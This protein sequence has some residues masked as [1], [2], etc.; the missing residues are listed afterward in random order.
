MSQT[1]GEL[2]LSV[3]L[4]ILNAQGN[5]K[6]FGTSLDEVAGKSKQ[7]NVTLSNTK[8]TVT[9]LAGAFTN[10]GLRVEG[11]FSIVRVMQSTFGSFVQEYKYF[12][13]AQ[14]GLSSIASFKM[15]DPETANQQIQSLKAV[16]AGLLDIGSASTAM[17]NLLASNFT[18]EQSVELINRLSESAAF[19]RQS[20]LSFGEAVRSATEGIK[21]GNSILVDNAGVTKNL[22]VMLEEA[23][24]KA[25]DLMRA[26]Q[27]A[28]VRMA[29]FSSILRE[30]AGNVGDVD[31]LSSSA[32]GQFAKFEFAITKLKVSFGELITK[33]IGPGIDVLSSIIN[34]LAKADPFLAKLSIT[35][36]A[37]ASA[38]VV[39]NKS[40]GLIPYVLITAAGILA[41]LP[42]GLRAVAAAIMLVVGGVW[43][44][45]AA[46]AIANV[47]SGGLITAIGLIVTALAALGS[48][49]FGASDQA[50]NFTEQVN[51]MTQKLGETNS[52]L[53]KLS[54]LEDSFSITIPTDDDL[55]QRQDLLKELSETYPQLIIGVNQ[56][57]GELQSNSVRV[58]EVIQAE[59][60]LQEI[61]NTALVYKIASGIKD[62]TDEYSDQISTFEKVKRETEDYRKQA[63]A[64]V[65]ANAKLTKQIDNHKGSTFESRRELIN[66][67]AELRSNQ[68]E[69]EGLYEKTRESSSEM[70]EGANAAAQLKQQ[71]ID[72]ISA[73]L[74]TG[75]L[76]DVFN[77][78]TMSLG[79][80]SQAAYS[81]QG[82]FAS[83]STNAIANLLGI[84][85]SAQN[86]AQVLWA[87]SKG[88]A[89]LSKG[90]FASAEAMFNIA[91]G[92]Q[93]PAPGP[94]PTGTKTSGTGKQKSSRAPTGDKE[95]ELNEEK[96]LLT[97]IAEI[98]KKIA[99][100][101]GNVGALKDLNEELRE[102][103]NE[104]QYVRTGIQVIDFAEQLEGVS[105]SRDDLTSGM[106][107]AAK[108]YVEENKKAI[109]EIDRLT[110]E[111]I[112]DETKRKR[113]QLQLDR[114]LAIEE[115]NSRNIDPAIKKELISLT[116]RKYNQEDPNESA[117]KTEQLFS[118]SLS[119]ASQI[120]SVLG[121]GAETFAGQLISGLQQGLSLANSFA[122]LLS[123][124]LNI[125]GG[126]GLFSLLG[127]AGGGSVPG[128]GSR[129]T[130]PAMLTPG[131]FVVKKAVVNKIGTGFFEW[132]NG[133]GLF[134][135]IAGKYASGGLVTQQAAS[136]PQVYIINSKVRGNDLDLVLKRTNRI[137]N[138][139]LT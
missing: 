117:N 77:T 139:R 89:F 67:R 71:L 103:R 40:M 75:N 43:A 64:L 108:L 104:L 113:A 94:G 136:Q 33:A 114:K 28:G 15:V 107:E 31:K 86:M 125:S 68:V 124:I 101:A 82:V 37:L 112:K 79:N 62:I 70:F 30:T 49:F 18:L 123:A 60:D 52:A 48:Y 11:F 57:N 109:G 85:G 126:G 29:L 81:L 92:I 24:F 47:A 100:N 129:D 115:I 58:K 12:T 119:F 121:I 90:D 54:A 78:L 3:L 20:S 122:S 76:T 111:S 8:E 131:E 133:G 106:K 26:G 91:K 32:A 84:S 9:K 19:G 69:L 95:E 59:R 138:R 55:S 65:V 105:R 25:Q 1:I 88:Q 35:V 22:S 13:S 41:S 120:S 38:F 132:L 14:T 23:G 72:L 42:S 61:R 73:G 2:K 45:N 36:I 44:Y 137:N 96:R 17:K 53:Q 130:V 16:K 83:L 99:A 116:D 56:Y 66:L 46:I 93:G 5:A 87:I 80:S 50:S 98:E 118:Q 6:K 135:S 7:L 128:S 63:D 134:T 10:A 102:L 34:W 21:N 4:E 110:I 97:E 74:R 39:L 127:F 51:E 27:D